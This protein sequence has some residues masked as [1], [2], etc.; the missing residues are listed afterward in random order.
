MG[1]FVKFLIGLGLIIT[2]AA[3]GVSKYKKTHPPLQ[4]EPPKAQIEMAEKAKAIKKDFE[5][6][7][8]TLGLTEEQKKKLEQWMKWEPKG[9]TKEEKKAHN[10]E[11]KTILNP[12][13]I[14]RLKQIQDKQK[15]NT[16][17]LKSD[18]EENLKKML[19]EADYQKFQANEKKRQEQ[20]KQYQKTPELPKQPEK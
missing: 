9:K 13:Q 1:K 10:D 14:K 4:Y 5:L 18:K 20:K 17:K 12:D 2:A 7:I 3:I 8:I 19:G 16:K 11:L 15:D 6:D